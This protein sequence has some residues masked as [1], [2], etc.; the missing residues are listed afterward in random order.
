MRVIGSAAVTGH[1]A[2]NFRYD[3]FVQGYALDLQTFR[4]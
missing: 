3:T 4:N 2:Y 1:V